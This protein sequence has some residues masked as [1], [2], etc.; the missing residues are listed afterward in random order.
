MN[1]TKSQKKFIKKNL[2]KLSSEEIAQKLNL[3]KEELLEYLK[4]VLPKK[5]YEKIIA[6]QNPSPDCLEPISESPTKN[7]KKW[8]TK[9]SL[10]LV[11]LALLVIIVYFNSLGNEFLSDDIAGIVQDK[12][13][14]NFFFYLFHW[15]INSARYFF[16]CLVF[17]L[18]GLNPTFFRLIN[19]FFH[20]G[21][22]WLI[23]ALLSLLGTYQLAF[24][25][26][27]LFAV[28]PLLSEAVVWVSGG[29]YAQYTFFVLLS[30]LFY[31]L[32]RKDGWKPKWYWLSV[33][34]FIPAVFTTEK[35]V[36]LSL[37]LFTFELSANKL[38]DN[39]KKLIPYFILTGIIALMVF[40]GGQLNQRI[41]ALQSS[42]YQEKGFYNPLTQIPTAIANYL[43][44]MVWPDKLTLYHSE[45]V[46]SNWQYALMMLV[47]L[48]Y[49]GLTIYTFIK[50]QYRQYF[51]WLS[52][53]FIGLSPMITPLKVAWIVA[54]RYV[55]LGSLGIFVMIGL[56][57]QKITRLLKNKIYFYLIWGA[58]LI[59][60]SVRT[61]VRNVDWKNQDNLWL[62]AA[63]TSP[64]SPQ[65]HNNLGDLYS[66]HGNF[67]K[68]VQEFSAAIA[69]LPNYGDA[70]HNLANTYLQMGKVDLAV[71][72]YQK[73]LTFNP[74]LWQS[75][76]NLAAIYAQQGRLDLTLEHLRQAVNLNPQN[77]NLLL[78]LG[79]IYYDSGKKEEAIKIWEEVLKMDPGNPDAQKL[80]QQSRKAQ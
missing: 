7:L 46:F 4:S 12:N 71:E 50:K 3:T 77:P 26:A 27:S 21:N 59:A 33:L 66:R 20:L 9:N 67:E 55:Y 49:F 72:N 11:F 2:R 51:F 48:V 35:A 80:L 76:Q 22:V 54:E 74:G 5:K 69:L 14:G 62:A 18:F 15:T 56:G 17:K 70:Y 10:P 42:Y 58:I 32:A 30:F 31:L 38:K 45:M 1:L 8:L 29:A 23:Y 73:A 24:I 65:N 34:S 47:T 37:L 19:I 68:A 16:Y 78:N 36:V 41:S 53:L 28:H 43:W 44:L 25:V 52:F 79:V 60:L 61:I 39:W 40:S 63:R 64:S 57:L 75:H 6:S 13:M